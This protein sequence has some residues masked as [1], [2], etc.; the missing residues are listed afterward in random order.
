MPALAYEYYQEAR[1]CWYV[2]VFVATIVTCQMCL[3][4]W[5]RSHYRVVGGVRGH[6]RL[7]GRG[8]KKQR[9]VRVD[10]ARFAELVQEASAD[11]ILTPIEAEAL[12]RM[13]VELRN[14]YMHV[15]DVKRQVAASDGR[16]FF[17]Q[18][19]RIV[20]PQLVG[21]GVQHQARQAI[22]LTVRLIS[23]LSARLPF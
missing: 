4:E 21:E 20:A 17:T 3:E 9:R 11:G 1:L 8:T 18:H 6:L 23:S 19:L 15:E 12:D 5:F 14:R 16:D 2:G 13:R 7:T 10:D 22:A